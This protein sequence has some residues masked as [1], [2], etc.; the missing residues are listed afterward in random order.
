VVTNSV[1]DRG[2]MPWTGPVTHAAGLLRRFHDQ[3]RLTD[4]DAVAG[5]VVDRDGPV[6]RS[7]PPDPA[8]PGAT[9]EN[10]EGLGA[11]PAYW[12]RRQVDFFA[13]RG[14][15]VE[16]KTYDY[17]EP[18]DLPALLEGAGF[19]PEEPEVV[20]LGACADL[21]HDVDLPG[22]V[23]LRDVGSD[24]D[25]AR[26]AVASERVWGAA[27][28][29]VVEALREEQRAA[30]ELMTATVVEDADSGEVLSYALLR[31][32]PGTDFC[33]LWGGSTVP[34]QRRRGFYRALTAHRA[35]RALALGYP[36]A[37]VDTSPDSRPVLT[38]LG[39]HPVCG[40]RPYVRDPGG[41]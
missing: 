32:Q 17:D 6:R 27:D 16:W 37:R 21:V 23:R 38:A 11:D 10:P 8:S 12:V 14:Q 19:V 25:W 36:L 15:S 9:V 18:A 20:L 41:R 35:R 13:G 24:E 7:Y 29:W 39:M 33:G 40:T 2:R 34:G 28:A 22:G 1:A 4:R 26:V 31:L 5:L 30:P 3:V